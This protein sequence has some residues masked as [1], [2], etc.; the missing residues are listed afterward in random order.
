MAFAGGGLEPRRGLNADFDTS[1]GD[2]EGFRRVYFGSPTMKTW[3]PSSAQDKSG[4]P[5]AKT[6]RRDGQSPQ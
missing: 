4:N 2:S 6:A 1:S 5:H 3:D